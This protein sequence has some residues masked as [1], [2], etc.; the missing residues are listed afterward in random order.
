M[1]RVLGGTWHDMCVTHMEELSLFAELLTHIVLLHFSY[2]S[3]CNTEARALCT[4]LKTDMKT[5]TPS[6][7]YMQHGH[8]LSWNSCIRPLLKIPGPRRA[9]AVL[10]DCDVEYFSCMIQ[11][12]SIKQRR[13]KRDIADIPFSLSAVWF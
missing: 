12:I 4:R 1:L 13:M 10:H 2:S 6:F 7:Y 3:T 8:P 5:K 9:H 11:R